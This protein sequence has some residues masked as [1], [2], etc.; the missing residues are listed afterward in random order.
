MVVQLLED[1]LPKLSSSF[2]AHNT[3]GRCGG[4]GVDTF[5]INPSYPLS[6]NPIAYPP[7]ARHLEAGS[8]YPYN[9]AAE[10][11]STAWGFTHN[12]GS[13]PHT[14]GSLPHNFAHHPNHHHH[15][16]S[17]SAT[18]RPPTPS[19]TIDP[20]TSSLSSWDAATFD[21]SLLVTK[22]AST[23]V[24]QHYTMFNNDPPS[25]STIPEKEPFIPPTTGAEREFDENGIG[26]GGPGRCGGRRYTRPQLL[27]LGSALFV[28]CAAFA[29]IS[30]MAPFFPYQVE[31]RGLGSSTAGVIFSTYSLVLVVASP[32]FGK[33]IPLLNLREAYLVSTAVVGIAE[34]SFGM[35]AFVHDPVMFIVVSICL[36]TLAALGTACFLTI[37][38]AIIPIIFP[39]DINT[40]NGMLET[41]VGVGMCVGP[42][43]GVWLYSVGGFFLPFFCLGGFILLTVIVSCFI[44]PEDE[45]HM[46]NGGG[47]GDRETASV[48]RI[49]TRPGATIS[50]VILAS[51]ALCFGALYP[52][53]QPHMSKLGVSVE[54]VGLMFL[55][56]SAVYTVSAPLIGLATDR[57]GWM[58]GVMLLGL[59]LTALALILI[60]NS[61]LLPRVSH[62]EMYVQDVVG[63]VL[64]ALSSAMTIVPTYGAVLQSA[65]NSGETVDIGTY[66]VVGG[67]WSSCYS[68]GEMLGPLYAGFL[69][70]VANFAAITTVTAILPGVLAVVLG[71]YMCAGR[72]SKTP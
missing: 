14:Y 38:Y 30:I 43:L 17:C 23:R 72:L 25:Y 33:I 26:V 2:P 67:L 52:T 7:S 62:Q 49:A 1:S 32:I 18:N 46:M 13:V 6:G 40:M 42:A 11:S 71:A 22:K 59:V 63:L 29:S 5:K 21:P 27:L 58:W 47:G 3:E 41:A 56:V 54:G 20:F 60:G 35:V 70:E 45:L 8:T 31:Q 50:L 12:F 48:W 68:C 15:N 53:L 39:G 51:A 10:S 61:P 16:N 57:Y 4:G 19:F 9:P 36:R 64:L 28:I 44:F 65:A 55:M 34:I 69:T 66:S 37:I 24:H